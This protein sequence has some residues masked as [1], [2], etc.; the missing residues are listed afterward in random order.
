MREGGRRPIGPPLKP[1]CKGDP[2]SGP[3]AS[4]EASDT[5]SAARL[6][7]SAEEAP[8]DVLALAQAA[9]TSATTCSLCSSSSSSFALRVTRLGLTRL[10][11][12]EGRPLSATVRAPSRRQGDGAEAEEAGE[13]EGSKEGRKVRLSAEWSGGVSISL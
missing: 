2:Y 1:F 6:S 8:E 12:E 10:L 9:Q 11:A 4:Q 13:G 5:A 3:L 7:D